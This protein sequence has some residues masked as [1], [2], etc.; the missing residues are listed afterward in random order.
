MTHMRWLRPALTFGF[1]LF[2]LLSNARSGWAQAHRRATHRQHDRRAA[3]PAGDRAAELR[4]RRRARRHR[5][6]AAR[7]RPDAQLPVAPVRRL[8]ARTPASTPTSSS[9]RRP[10]E[11]TASMALFDRLQIGVALPLHAG[12]QGRRSSTRRARRPARTDTARGFGDL[13]LEA[14]TQLAV[15][16][17]DDQYGVRAARRLH[18]PD[19][20]ARRRV[21]RRAGR[22][23][24]AVLPGR[25][26]LHRPHQGDRRTADRRAA[27]RRQPRR[28]AARVVAEL[29]RRRRSPAA[30]R[31][32][33]RLR[34]AQAHRADGRAVR[35]QRPVGLHQVL[36]GR[37]PVRGRR[38]AARSASPACGR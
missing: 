26:E 16:G 37:E 6:Q 35:A 9:I 23:E 38:R 34:G 11:L 24:H 22:S 13:R 29:R 14:K 10:A 5:T 19:R 1:S 17:D 31:R 3:L 32:R 36:L 8:H 7:V 25:Q 15:F 30:L 33:R 18:R 20:E 28:A 2:L 4:H 12:P 27:R 21:A